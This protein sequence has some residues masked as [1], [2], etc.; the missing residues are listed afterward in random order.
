MEHYGDIEPITRRS[1]ANA[2][3]V[4]LIVHALSDRF[5]GEPFPAMSEHYRPSGIPGEIGSVA[6]PH[7]LRHIEGFNIAGDYTSIDVPEPPNA[8]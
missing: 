7:E 8:A 6:L 4:R 3:R 5:T 1:K 2:E